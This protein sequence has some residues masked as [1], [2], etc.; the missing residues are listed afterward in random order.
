MRNLKKTLCLVLAL[1]FVLGLCTVGVSGAFDDVDDITV[2]YAN[3]IKAMNGLGILTGDDND[4]DGKM[5]FR[6]DDNVTRAEAAT[7]IARIMLGVENAQKWPARASFDDVSADH[8]AARAISFC[9]SKGII[10]GYGDN[11]FRPSQNV[12]MT[13]LAKMLLSAVGYGGKGEFVGADWNFN[14]I[15]R[16]MKTKLIK[17]LLPEDQDWDGYANREVTSLMCFNTMNY[18]R[19]VE[20]DSNTDAY[21]DLTGQGGVDIGTFAKSV[22]GLIPVT[23]I[24]LQNKASGNENG[25]VVEYYDTDYAMYVEVTVVTEKDDDA[26]LIGQEVELQ[27]RVEEYDNGKEYNK[28]Y[29]MDPIG[30]VVKPAAVVG[31]KAT[32]GYNGYIYSFFNAGELTT[33]GTIPGTAAAAKNYTGEFILDSDGN[34]L[35]YRDSDYAVGV[36]SI[37]AKGVA[38]V[39][40]VVMD[41]IPAGAK[42]GD[43][44]TYYT[45]GSKHNAVACTSEEITVSARKITTDPATATDYYSYNSDTV[46]AT[47]AAYVVT[48]LAV[49]DTQLIDTTEGLTVGS[50]YTIW[51]DAE[52][53]AF[54]YKIVTA[55]AA[56]KDYYLFLGGRSVSETAAYAT[57]PTVTNYALIMDTAGKITEIKTDANLSA[58]SMGVVYLTASTTVKGT[59]TVTFNDTGVI[60]AGAYAPSSTVVFDNAKFVCFSGT[61]AANIQLLSTTLKPKTNGTIYYAY[62]TIPASGS[63]TVAVQDVTAVWFSAAQLPATADV[64][65]SYIYVTSADTTTRALVNGYAKNYFSAYKDGAV[66][67]DLYTAAAGPLPGGIGFYTY[68]DDTTGTDRYVLTK[69]TATALTTTNG[70]AAIKTNIVKNGTDYINGG[71]LYISGTALDLSKVKVVIVPAVAYANPTMVASVDGIVAMVQ[72]G[73]TVTLEFVASGTTTTAVVAGSTQVIYVTA[74]A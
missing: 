66:L 13:E 21:V 9:K 48:A 24:V 58:A 11:T 6:P 39:G 31:K 30:S 28:A 71:K 60:D 42:N 16:A 43:Y 73:K 59:N 33:A 20:V 74:V 4:G 19:Q 45:V 36:L 5:E 15:D 18:I 62:K 3:A 26:D 47:A 61:T 50:K 64:T 41:T 25:T 72:A 68:Q 38:K 55:A 34:V 52:G 69:I 32:K 57:T 51:K 56:A 23:G 29:F 44:V 7:I 27:Y 49:G 17:T 46:C 53:Y 35:A 40:T 70:T 2:R 63:S 37:D 65:G 10:N 54:A 67:D 14:V 12:T 8:W 1:V 22:W